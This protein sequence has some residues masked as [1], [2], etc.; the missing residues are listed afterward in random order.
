MERKVGK[1]GV[2]ILIKLR[3][4]NKLKNKS[5]HTQVKDQNSILNARQLIAVML[6]I[7]LAFILVSKVPIFAEE[8]IEINMKDSYDYHLTYKTDG[9]QGHYYVERYDTMKYGY[10]DLVYTTSSNSIVVDAQ[11]I[12]NLT[13][14]CRSMYEDECRKVFGIDP[15]NN[16]NYYKWYFIEKNHF[17]ANV[18]TVNPINE[19]TFVD[20]PKP[21][22]VWVNGVQWMEDVNYY[23]VENFGTVLSNVPS[24]HSNVDIYFKSPGITGPVANIDTSRTVTVV[25]EIISFDG[26]GSYDEDGEIISYIWDFGNGEFAGGAEIDHSYSEIGIY[27]V[28]LMVKDNEYLV[29]RAYVNITVMDPENAYPSILYPI[30]NQEQAEDSPPWTLKLTNFEFDMKD[31]GEDLNWYLT[32]VNTSLYTVSGEW[33]LDDLLI[34]HP[35]SNA[36]GNDE[37]TIWLVDSDGFTVSQTLWINLTPV[38]DMPIFQGA[39]DLVLHYDDPYSFNYR[40]YIYDVDTQPDDLEMSTTDTSGGEYIVTD[41]LVATYNYPY[42]L[43][44]QIIFVT[45][46]VVDGEV[47]TE[48]TIQ[49]NITSNYVPKLD[50]KLPNIV[51]YEGSILTFIFDLDDYFTDPDEDAIFFSFGYTHLT[52]KIH[53]NHSVDVA[54]LSDWTGIEY[55]TF[56]ATDPIGALAEDTIEVTVLYLNDAPVISKV[57]NLFVRYDYE[58]RFNL[59]P[60][61]TDPDNVTTELIIWTSD[62][63]HITGSDENNLLIILYYPESML[64]QI[65]KIRITVSDGIDYGYQDIFVTV[66]SDWPPELHRDLPDI[67]FVE[68]EPYTDAFNLED[69]FFDKDGDALYYTTGNI[70]IHI[71]IKPDKFVDFSAPEDWSGFEVVTFR[72][73]DPTGALIEDIII[74]TVLPVNDPPEIYQ[75]PVQSGEVGEMWRLDLTPYINDVDNDI[76]DLDIT[77]DNNNVIV[78]GSKLVFYGSK[79]LDGNITLTINDGE[80]II[81]GEIQV[82]ILSEDEEK[83]KS[84]INSMIWIWILV[85]VVLIL[86]LNEIYKFIKRPKSKDDVIILDEDSIVDVEPEGQKFERVFFPLPKIKEVPVP[87]IKKLGF[88]TATGRDF[89][90]DPGSFASTLEILPKEAVESWYLYYEW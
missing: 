13:V 65:I 90:G 89:Q 4:R 87:K 10:I 12:K 81:N 51:M 53:D 78:S 70:N 41:N 38:N 49:V 75:I 73:T 76:G 58:Y 50:N 57:P 21:Y 67:V 31:A 27:G 17:N 8:S 22:E 61:I 37:V 36:Y 66:T 15:W 86:A 18:D 6:A 19:L 62:P 14:Y 23:H 39:P 84:D 88:A 26:S 45:I 44:N 60:Y 5:L 34:F 1:K 63:E 74:A 59:S 64:G 77:V 16:T 2:V 42:S 55:V 80:A 83:S 56:R 48:D 82:I 7:Y 46:T 28:I 79:D 25:N 43:L 11:N 72:A 52:V 30:P 69:Y 9:R 32:D 29:D 47:T 24:G 3:S 33:S 68:D 85:L 71:N 35:V 40:P 54:S 20:T